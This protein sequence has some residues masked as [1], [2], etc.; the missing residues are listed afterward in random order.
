M[1]N[2]TEGQVEAEA[3]KPKR[4]PCRAK[5]CN[6][7]AGAKGWCRDHHRRLLNAERAGAR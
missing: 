3:P 6:G 7:P 1:T 4:K 2:K 5:G